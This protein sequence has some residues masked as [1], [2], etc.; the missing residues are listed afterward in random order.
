MAFT[1]ATPRRTELARLYHWRKI[2]GYPL[3]VIV[4]LG[5]AEA[6]S[7]SLR[8]RYMVL[9][10]CSLA[11]VFT[12]L[13]PFLLSR[14]ISKRI[15]HEIEL[16]REKANLTL[17]NGALDE[18]RKNLHTL[19]AQLTESKRQAEEASRQNRHFLAYMSHEFRTPMHAILA[20][21]KMALE[22]M[23]SGRSGE[24]PRNI[25][26]CKSGRA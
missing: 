5:K 11:V 14:E 22:D 8:Q 21:T 2:E 3:I 12:L 25:R 20:Y 19:N 18:E 10:A 9:A 26:K 24:R 4:G 23:E 16:N 13:M 1:K 6:L 15:S 17:A 7:A